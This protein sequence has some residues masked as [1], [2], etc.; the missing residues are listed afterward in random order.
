MLF[1]HS[2]NF[3]YCDFKLENIM[4][5][6]NTNQI[7]NLNLRLIDFGTVINYQID[8]NGCQAST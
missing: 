8:Q 3:A 2:K 6:E 4:L 7:K 1:V 5:K